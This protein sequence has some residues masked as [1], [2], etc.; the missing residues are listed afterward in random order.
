M[1]GMLSEYGVQPLVEEI[2]LLREENE[3]LKRNY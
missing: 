2:R 1:E 3:R